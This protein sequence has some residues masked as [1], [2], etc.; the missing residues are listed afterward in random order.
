MGLCLRS[1]A[2]WKVATLTS[3]GAGGPDDPD[4]DGANYATEPIDSSPNVGS[5]DLHD[6]DGKSKIS[7]I[8]KRIPLQGWTRRITWWALAMISLVP[9]L[10]LPA[11]IYSNYPDGRIYPYYYADTVEP[12]NNVRVYLLDTGIN[13]RH[14]EF[15]G[16]L[17]P[18]ITYG[19][20]EDDWDIDW[21]FPRVDSREWF[22]DRDPRSGLPVPR[23]YTFSY[24]D[25]DSSYSNEGIHP[26]YSDFRSRQVSQGSLTPH[27]T[28]VSAF[29]SSYFFNPLIPDL[30][31]F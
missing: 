17:K 5:R 12:G 22:Y 23:S 26:A 8:L 11:Y 16:R 25:P 6:E 13:M 27:G 31:F 24:I 14:P 30:L 7:E 29:I 9:G 15:N 20:T 21:L 19:Q 1:P 28:R 18:G 2:L 4:L 3:N 10:P